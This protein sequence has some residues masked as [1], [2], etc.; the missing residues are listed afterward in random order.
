MLYDAIVKNGPDN[1]DHGTKGYYFG[2]NGEHSWYDISRGIA[3]A[4]SDRGLPGNAEPTPFT[5]PELIKYF[6]SEV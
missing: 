2:E 3:S 1:V 5:V 4:M 6:G